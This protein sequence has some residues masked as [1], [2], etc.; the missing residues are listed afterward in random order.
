MT[1]VIPAGQFDRVEDPATGRNLVVADSFKLVEQSPVT[2]FSMFM[3][4]MEG[5]VDAAD[6]IFFTFFSYGFMCMLIRVGAF[7]AGVGALIRALKDKDKY[8]LPILIWIFGLMGA[9]FG[10][11]E[12]AYGFI[13]VVMGIAIALGYDAITGAVVVMGSV[14]LGFASAFVNPYTI[15]IAQT[16]A[17]LPLFSGLFF[18]VIVFI[19]TMSIF[20]FYVMRYANKI[21]ENPKKSYVFGMDFAALSN[22]TKEE[23][24][25]LEL[26]ARHKISLILFFL[27]IVTFVAGAIMYGW[28]LY[29][30]SA[31][32]IIMMFV[33]GLVNNKSLSEIC[34]IFI[35]ISK[36]IIFGAFVIGI[37]RSV[38]IVLQKGN[39]ID[40]VC[41]YLA[42]SMQNLTSTF[43]AI[44]MFFFQT[45]LNFF[46]P[47]GSGQAATSMPIMVPLADLLGINRQI[48]CLAFQFGDGFSN[49][50][51]PTQAAV[52]CAI[53]G[54]T[55]DR[56]Y[57][58]FGPLYG[59]LLIVQVVFMAI[60][61]AINYGPF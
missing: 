50:F 28:Y 39:I 44:V 17:E 58:F 54:I 48:A 61:V 9:S 38:L 30:L 23:M 22:L 1:Y 43:A 19:T 4:I 55:L 56:W 42:Q 2:P 21:K 59:I 24:I 12:E 47:S 52:D 40:T 35:D 13:P 31:I 33:I 45:I 6:I 37:A 41:F 51:W 53:A 26:T 49:I 15:A 25:N 3:S 5:M 27:T 20:T 16:I 34:E 32:F 60:A 8:I 10:M 29:E 7:D 57:K 14:A 11:Y 46:I 36:N 18:R